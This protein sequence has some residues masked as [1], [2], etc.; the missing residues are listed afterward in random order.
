MR[1]YQSNYLRH[2]LEVS[3]QRSSTTP[4]CIYSSPSLRYI[5]ITSAFAFAFLHLIISR[6]HESTPSNVRQAAARVAQC[7]A[8]G[9]PFAFFFFFFFLFVLRGT[10]SLFMSHPSSLFS[11]H[12]LSSFSSLMLSAPSDASTG[13]THTR[14]LWNT[15]TNSNYF[16]LQIS[17][18]L[19]LHCI[20]VHCISVTH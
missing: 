20:S 12:Y 2:T 13:D 10:G 15:A 11:H 5:S 19:F 7:P 4:D 1:N 8:L 16:D 9:D 3:Y 17:S 6:I 14:S 18:S